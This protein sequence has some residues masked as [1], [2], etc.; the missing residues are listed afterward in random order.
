MG[1]RGEDMLVGALCLLMTLF[2]AW[3]IWSALQKDEVPLYR[4]RLRRAET[5]PAK[6]AAA[7]ALNVALTALLLL[8][9]ADL[10]LGLGLRGR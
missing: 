5:A 4:K 1:A 9:A 6:F 8:I 2:N 7:V 10:L 3:R